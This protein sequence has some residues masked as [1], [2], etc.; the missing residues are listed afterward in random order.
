MQPIG[1]VSY[2]SMQQVIAHFLL[3]GINMKAMVPEEMCGTT[4]S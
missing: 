3:E 4:Q 1:L 2:A